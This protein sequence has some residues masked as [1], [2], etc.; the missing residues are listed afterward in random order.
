MRNGA[1]S[2]LSSTNAPPVVVYEPG[3]LGAGGGGG[4][5]RRGRAVAQSRADAESVSAMDDIVFL[6]DVD[7]TL[8]DNDR[9]QE[10]LDAH[11]ADELRRG[12]PRPLLGDFRGAVRA[13]S[14]TPTISARWN[15][16]GSRT[17]TI[18]A[19]S[20]M[21]NWLVD[22]PFAERL[23]PGALEAVAMCASGAARSCCRTA[24]RCSSRARS[25]GRACGT[26]S[27]GEVLIFVHKEQE[28]DDVERLYPARRYVLIDD[29]LRILWRSRRSGATG[30]RRCFRGRATTRA[31]PR[32]W[33]L[34]RRR[35]SRSRRS[36]TLSRSTSTISRLRGSSGFAGRCMR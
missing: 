4:A 11:L 7:N 1:S 3:T 23:Y 34:I 18:R 32:R 27:T 8:L 17:C 10:D 20:R 9:V 2:S 21:A 16:T 33:R 15:A 25:S 29:K 19:C 35:T 30:W 24:T 13:R 12:D 6:F 36:A 26:P 14:A 22:Y 31:T 5:D 28:L